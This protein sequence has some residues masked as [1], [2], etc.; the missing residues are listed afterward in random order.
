[1]E[2]DMQNAAHNISWIP[3]VVH[4]HFCEYLANKTWIFGL[5]GSYATK[6]DLNGEVIIWKDVKDAV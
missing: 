6:Q 2:F 4:E 3:S 1:M 5:V